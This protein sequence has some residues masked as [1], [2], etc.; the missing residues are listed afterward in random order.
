MEAWWDGRMCVD[1][2]VCMWRAWVVACMPACKACLPR[3]PCV[4]F[5]VCVKDTHFIWND[6]RLFCNTGY[7]S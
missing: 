5:L 4:F 2:T 6:V 3:L 7:G 1:A